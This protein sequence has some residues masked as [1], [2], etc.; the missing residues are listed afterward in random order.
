M[1][2]NRGLLN[3]STRRIIL[4]MLPKPVRRRLQSIWRLQY[5]PLL[6]QTS[7][8]RLRRTTPISREFGLDRGRP[9][10]RYYIENFL[11]RQA[12]DIRGHVLEVADNSYTRKYGGAHVTIS[13]VLDLR[14]DNPQATI[15]ADLTSANHIPS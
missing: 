14:E 3:E 10:D 4:R 9:T 12:G 13:D 2:A 7:F 11:A 6:G 15:V 1:F 5:H 8:D